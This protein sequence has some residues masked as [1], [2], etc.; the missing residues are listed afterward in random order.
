MLVRN[1]FQGLFVIT[2]GEKYR[3]VL[4]TIYVQTDHVKGKNIFGTSAAK[5][6]NEIWWD[7]YMIG[8]LGKETLKFFSKN[9]YVF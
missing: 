9:D 6:G 8:Q 5:V 7:D 3:P 2:N 1:D 4:E